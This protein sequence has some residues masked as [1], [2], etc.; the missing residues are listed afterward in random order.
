[1]FEGYQ[2]D[3][4]FDEMFDAGGETRP[5]YSLVR[6]RVEELGREGK[7]TAE[8]LV[9]SRTHDHSTAIAVVG[10]RGP[11][12]HALGD[13][14]RHGPGHEMRPELPRRRRG[15]GQNGSEAAGNELGHGG[16]GEEAGT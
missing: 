7:P 13:S 11:R 3:G 6:Q 9:H 1:M 4:F 2:T 8:H 5:H 15:E 12:V 10:A 14:C 16:S